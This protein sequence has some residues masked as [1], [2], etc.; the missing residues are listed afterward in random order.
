MTTAFETLYD[1]AVE[2]QVNPQ[3]R[4]LT[5]HNDGRDRDEV[6]TRLRQSILAL[7]MPDEYAMSNW[8]KVRIF[9]R[10]LV[11]RAQAA[12]SDTEVQQLLRAVEANYESFEE[13]VAALSETA[14]KTL[15]G[16]RLDEYVRAVRK[17]TSDQVYAELGNVTLL[18]WVDRRWVYWVGRSVQDL[19][20]DEL[21]H[22][23]DILSVTQSTKIDGMGLP[24]AANFFADIGL[25][26]FAKPDLHV[27]PIINLLQLRDGE[28]SAFRGL[29]AIAQAENE[30][31]THNRRFNWLMESGGLYPRYLDR[32]IYLIGS[33]NYNLDGVKNKRQAPKRRDLMRDALI[34]AGLVQ[35][36]YSE[37]PF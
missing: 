13:R 23:I 37:L 8:H 16:R 1:L 36:R 17:M 5:L 12:V 31:L 27:T 28:R 22:D 34:T 2:I 25:P 6:E 7:T 9:C 21:L 20:V 11:N 33:D 15:K 14:E 3:Y 24:L 10:N 32:V 18:E 29:V 26:G 19:D 4:H 30:V 35:A